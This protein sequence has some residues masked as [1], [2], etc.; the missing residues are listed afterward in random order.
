MINSC[1][2][3]TV[4]VYRGLHTVVVRNYGAVLPMKKSP[5]AP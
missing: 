1:C 4:D 5:S 3:S 2:V